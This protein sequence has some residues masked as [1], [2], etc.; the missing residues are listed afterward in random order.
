MK[1]ILIILIS[2]FFNPITAFA[3]WEAKVV[4]VYDGDILILSD[5]GRARIIQLFGVDCPEKE[6]PYGLKATNYSRNTVVGKDISIVPVD[7]KRYQRC[8][9]YVGGKCLNEELLKIGYAWHDKRY[10]SDEKWAKME[11]KAV[12]Q[13]KGLWSQETAV[14]PW[15]FRGEE[16]HKDT[17]H[18][19]HTIKLG[20]K[21]KTGTVSVTRPPVKRR[22]KKE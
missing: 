20:G 10:S 14:P 8:V 15:K 21:H 17:L 1:A 3:T 6:Q 16:D 13:K 4:D 2:L 18:R 22:P 5:D 7:T 9:V 19:I 11:K 12:A